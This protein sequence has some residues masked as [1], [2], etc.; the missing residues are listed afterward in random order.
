[1][2]EQFMERA[3]RAADESGRLPL[4]AQPHWE[5]F[6][7]E[8][9]GLQPRPLEDAVADEPRRARTP[10]EC[11]TCRALGREDLV[12]HRGERLAVI[13]PGGCNLPF[14]ANVV[15]LDHVGLGDLD[16]AAL[17][18]MGVLVGHTFAALMALDEVGNVHLNKWENGGGHLSVNLLA[19]PMGV[20]QLRGSNLPLWA[21]MLP[22]TPEAELAVRADAVRA[23]LAS[24]RDSAE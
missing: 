11:G 3:R 23:A 15:A 8:V 12:L 16:D 14:V 18:E 6:P 17:A 4:G 19:R 9:D 7:F 22:P 5:V 13:R 2:T 1:M 24:P 10:E 20:L 21:D